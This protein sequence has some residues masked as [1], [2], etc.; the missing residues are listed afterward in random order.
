MRLDLSL[1]CKVLCGHD[2]RRVHLT[3]L[4]CRTRRAY[5]G[6]LPEQILTRVYLIT[7]REYPPRRFWRLKDILFKWCV[8]LAEML[9]S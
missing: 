7:V 4:Y 2:L 9:A 8:N 3:C 5:V 6:K 1:P